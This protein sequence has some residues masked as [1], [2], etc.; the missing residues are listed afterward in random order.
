MDPHDLE[1]ELPSLLYTHLFVM[2][3]PLLLALCHTRSTMELIDPTAKLIAVWG[4]LYLS[5]NVRRNKAAVSCADQC[6]GSVELSNKLSG[7]Q[8]V[9]VEGKSAG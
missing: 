1:K 3:S 4:N 6:V 9:L 5:L 2:R 8:H 7:L